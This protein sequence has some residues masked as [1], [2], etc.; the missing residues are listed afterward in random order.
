MFSDLKLRRWFYFWLVIFLQELWE[1]NFF[2]VI[3]SRK[4]L[5]ILFP[6]QS[7]VK[8]VREDRAEL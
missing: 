7:D 4:D 1:S 8:A 3:S 5:H 2:L 6:W